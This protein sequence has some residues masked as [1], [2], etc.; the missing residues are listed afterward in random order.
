MM[1]FNAALALFAQISLKFISILA[2][3]MQQS[4]PPRGFDQFR[5]HL[6]CKFG[7]E[8]AHSAQV[9]G[10]LV[11]IAISVFGVGEEVHEGSIVACWQHNKSRKINLARLLPLIQCEN[12]NAVAGGSREACSR[13]RKFER[14]G[15]LYSWFG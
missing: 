5:I 8:L 15:E 13:D 9:V 1:S 3:V 12:E 4:S 7:S 10:K 6:R 14:M 11:P 2:N